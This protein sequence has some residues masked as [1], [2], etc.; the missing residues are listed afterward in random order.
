MTEGSDTMVRRRDLLRASLSVCNYATC[1]VFGIGLPG[2]SARADGP[3][4][5]SG[6]S[7]QLWFIGAQR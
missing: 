3:A 2:G 7:Y 6:T 4:A 5:I 1:G